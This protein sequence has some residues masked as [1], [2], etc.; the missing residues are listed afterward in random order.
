MKQRYLLLFPCAA[1]VLYLIAFT[2]LIRWSPSDELAA[3]AWNLGL[4]LAPLLALLA[5]MKIAKERGFSTVTTLAVIAIVNTALVAGSR[6]GA[7]T[8]SD[9]HRVL[10]TGMLPE[11]PGKT[12]M[13]GVLL[14]LGLFFLLKKWW[15]L[16]FGMAD[17][18]ILGM[19][20][21]A[22]S[23]RMGCLVAGCCYGVET[24]SG[25]GICYG[26]G[27]TAFQDHFPLAET[28]LN[29]GYT[30]PL[31]PVQLLFIAG[32][33]VIFYFLWQYRKRLARPGAIAFLG[34]GLLMAQRFGLEFIRDADTNRGEMGRMLLGLKMVQWQSLFIGVLAFSS[35]AY[36]QLVSRKTSTPVSRMSSPTSQHWTQTL[37][38]FLII[39][40]SYVLQ[41]LLTLD[42]S[43]F[44]LVS[45]MPALW[46]L[47]WQIWQNRRQE[48]GW[49]MQLG[50]LSTGVL[51]LT[52]NPIDSVGN[53]PEPM[54][55]SQWIEFGS[56]GTFGE[57]RHKQ[58]S[59]DCTGSPANVEQFTIKTGF[60][61]GEFSYN[62][63]K[64]SNKIQLAGKMA[65]GHYDVTSDA[66]NYP[67]Q[68]NKF[69]SSSLAARLDLKKVGISF[70]FFKSNHSFNDFF[71]TGEVQNKLLPVL[72][73]RIGQLKNVFIDCRMY[74]DPTIGIALEPAFS[75]GI[76]Y[77]FKN[78]SGDTY[79]R[80]G[81]AFPST[82]NS[83][84]T[85]AFLL[86]GAF[87]IVKGSL[88]GS[89]S[90]YLGD[91]KMVN[92]GIKYRLNT[93]NK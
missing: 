3:L 54:R 21:A 51:L 35:W 27:T 9:W 18:L 45:C 8:T 77:G 36:I 6:I 22:V 32:S 47:A 39:A 88:Y 58:V 20:L 31:F 34:L 38:V 56:G 17:V 7:W 80:T 64:G 75:L 85:G 33:L 59:R 13:G 50:F 53:K 68:T 2:T 23:V 84:D 52:G 72:S 28:A 83:D 76:N 66:I 81:F 12:A 16:S 24:G 46:A 29:N 1:L 11:V 61:G 42:E 43:L 78:P 70:G 86:S 63:A 30:A 14:A 44:I 4:V 15:R 79:L 41:S 10:H 90:A 25:W 49:V 74:D 37:V 71:R 26:T 65:G 67:T 60:V 93:T 91:I 73:L 62:W 19:P 92:V 69:F 48:K 82:F 57:I 40:A 89:T 55:W 5:Q 87:P